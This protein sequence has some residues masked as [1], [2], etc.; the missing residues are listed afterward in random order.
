MGLMQAEHLATLAR[1]EVRQAS[2]LG[3][4]ARAVG[5]VQDDELAAQAFCQL[6]HGG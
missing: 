5:P 3:A 1:Q 2:G 4:L 6:G